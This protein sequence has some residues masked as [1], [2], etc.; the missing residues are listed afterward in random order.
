MPP[1]HTKIDADIAS[2]EAVHKAKNAAQAI[3]TARALQ[4]NSAAESAAYKVTETMGAI[5]RDSVEHVLAKGTEQEKSIVL[6][7]VPYICQDV[8]AIFKA[9]ARIQEM[10]EQTKKDLE[11]KD[12]KNDKKYVNQDQFVPVKSLAYGFAGAILTAFSGGLIYLVLN[13]HK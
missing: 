8:K 13:L 2:A 3:E 7:R 10:M 9:L 12:E 6:A 1:E 5:V 11:A 4:I